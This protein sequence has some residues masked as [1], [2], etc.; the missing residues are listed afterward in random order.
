MTRQLITNEDILHLTG[1][2]D[3]ARQIKRDS[4]EVIWASRDEKA[5]VYYIA[6]FNLSD[7]ERKIEIPDEKVY[8]I[9]DIINGSTG[10]GVINNP[11]LEIMELWDHRSCDKAGG[12]INAHGACLYRIKID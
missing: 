12:N 1:H 7:C 3:G 9:I 10:G 8:E 6:L 11:I 4:D 2:S 5:G